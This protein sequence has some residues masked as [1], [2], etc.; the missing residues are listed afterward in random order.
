LRFLGAI[1]YSVYLSHG[2]LLYLLFHV[3]IGSEVAQGLSIVHYVL[4]LG[5]ASVLIVLLSWLLYRTIERPWMR[6]K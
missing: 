1:S 6:K 5:L 4:N 2:I 3:C